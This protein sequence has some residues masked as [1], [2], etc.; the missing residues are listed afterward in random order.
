MNLPIP[1]IILNGPVGEK[2]LLLEESLGGGAFGIVFKAKEVGTDKIFAVKFPQ[3][4][5]FGGQSELTAFFNEVQAKLR[6]VII[7]CVV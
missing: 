7:L 2:T 4:A 1:G 3:F 6:S 5:V